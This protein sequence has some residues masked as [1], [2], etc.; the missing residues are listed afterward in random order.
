MGLLLG[1]NLIAVESERS[2]GAPSFY[3]PKTWKQD[4]YTLVV[5]TG[6]RDHIIDVAQQFS[7]LTAI[8]RLP[9]YGKLATSDVLLEWTG[10]KVFKIYPK[11]LKETDEKVEN[12]CWHSLFKNAVI[13][14]HFPIPARE[15]EKGVEILFE[16]MTSLTNVSYPTELYNG[17][18][19]KG[20]F[21]ALIPTDHLGE[22]IQW[23]FMSCDTSLGRLR[24]DAIA[25][26]ISTFFETRNIDL[27]RTARTFLGYCRRA[28]IHLGTED[29]D[30]ESI[31]RSDA[32]DERST[33]RL[34]R[35]AS[36]ALGSDG[37]GIFGGMLGFK[38][39]YSKGLQATTRS[40]D[41]SFYSK[42]L[43]ARN[44]LSL[45]YDTER[46]MGWLVSE[47]SVI[48]HITHGRAVDDP[49]DCIDSCNKA[50]YAKVLGDGGR[51]AW[52]AI[53]EG[54]K[55]N[56]DS[57]GR[58]L[59]LD[60]IKDLMTVLESR[61]ELAIERE[62][63][64]SNPFKKA[65]LQGWEFRDVA[66]LKFLCKRKQVP[67]DP[68][69]GG[70]WHR[71]IGDN[72]ELVVLFGK[73][74][75][76]LIRPR[77]DEKICR[78]LIPIP[79]GKQYLIASIPCLQQLIKNHTNDSSFPKLTSTMYWHGFLEEKLFDD[80]SCDRGSCS[81][82][83]QDLNKRKPDTFSA[84]T[85]KSDGAVIFGVKGPD[86]GSPHPPLCTNGNHVNRL[87]SRLIRPRNQWITFRRSNHN[88]STR[89][90]A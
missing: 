39:T 67:F 15:Q 3:I 11:P 65:C 23:H 25:K 71:I 51:A 16:V 17:V 2:S 84:E 80:C 77:K 66:D 27:L 36:I 89:L 72:P 88:G 87:T 81:S 33:L 38:V 20:P 28:E 57:E 29:A 79:Q 60:V 10:S 5:V 78:S 4:D 90:L 48:L 37:I 49:V 14:H 1:N 21:T 86:S 31:K 45:L 53:T 76:E 32:D 83:L 22:S 43:R 40:L 63:S 58:N 18:I 50:P 56:T 7:W 42:L 64:F 54:M 46:N 52:N 74:F 13:A 82:R 30:Y 85:Q 61:K 73:G 55:L 47:L 8:F 26:N 68:N 41:L 34:E 69:T 12:S 75:G 70:N 62:A 24:T 9:Q 44:E 19:L 59:G 6:A 35:E